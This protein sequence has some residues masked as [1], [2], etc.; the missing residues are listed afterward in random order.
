VTT[1]GTLAVVVPIK[2]FTS[3]KARLAEALSP[4]RRAI[5]A[6]Q[7]ADTVLRAAH[8]L[9]VFVVCDDDEVASWAIGHSATVVRPQRHGL[10]VAVAAGRDAA[11]TAGFARVLVV[12]SDL[13]RA[14][15]LASLDDVSVHVTVV[16]D[17]R[18]DG[19]NALLLPATGPFEFRYGP[20]SF[21]AHCAEAAAR[22]LAL[23]VVRRDDLALDLD[24]LDDLRLAGL[25]DD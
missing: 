25:S 12:H 23:R 7:C 5:L 20:G 17:R 6:R 15:S 3:A 10:N 22:G 24:T 18:D 11:A 13:P 4:E 1:R 9:P 19:T 14:K 21:D 8:P 16:P 2:S